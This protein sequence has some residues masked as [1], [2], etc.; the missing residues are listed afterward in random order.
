MSNLN[1]RNSL[2]LCTKTTRLLR[3][4]KAEHISMSCCGFLW[5]QCGLMR[6]AHWQPGDLKPSWAPIDMEHVALLWLPPRRPSWSTNP[7]AETQMPM[8]KNTAGSSGEGEDKVD[9]QS[10]KEDTAREITEDVLSGIWIQER[11]EATSRKL[12]ARKTL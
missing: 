10:E 12:D 3:E 1:H 2:S 6:L 5:S 4:F 7:A 8:F 11:T 9:P